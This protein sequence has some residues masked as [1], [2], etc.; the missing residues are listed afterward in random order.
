MIGGSDAGAHLDRM[1]GAPYPT[2]FLADCI[3]GRKLVSL[4]RAVQLMTSA[5][6]SLFGLRD[7]G[8][9]KAGAMADIFVFDPLTVDSDQAALVRDLPGN[10]AR[11]TAG[12]QGVKWVVVNGVTIVVDGRP[13]GSTPGTVLRSG[14]DTATVT[15]RPPPPSPARP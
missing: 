12:S 15:T 10:S 9:L 4:E 11:L 8:T 2:R 1:C 6:A 13:T 7:R 14:R 5:P 3:R